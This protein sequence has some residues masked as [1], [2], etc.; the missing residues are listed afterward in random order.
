MDPVSELVVTK[1]LSAQP[2]AV[3]GSIQMNDLVLSLIKDI[4]PLLDI[5]FQSNT[6]LLNHVKALTSMVKKASEQ[7]SCNDLNLASIIEQVC[8]PVLRMFDENKEDRKLMHAV[9]ELL[10]TTFISPQKTVGP[11]NQLMEKLSSELIAIC[12]SSLKSGRSELGCKHSM[13]E[14]KLVKFSESCAIEVLSYILGAQ[15][16]I[17]DT[18]SSHFALLSETE[19]DEAFS[20]L[21]DMVR[22]TNINTTAKIVGSLIM[23]ILSLDPNRTFHKVN[24]LYDLALAFNSEGSNDDSGSNYGKAYLILCALADFILPNHTTTVTS[25]VRKNCKFWACIQTGLISND[26]LTRKRSMYL[27]KRALDVTKHCRKGIETYHEV[28][29]AVFFWSPETEK[30]TDVMWNDLILLLETLDEKQVHVLNPLMPRI[31]NLI[32]ATWSRKEGPSLL[33]TSW[34]WILFTKIQKHDSTYV[35]KWG[36]SVLLELDLKQCPLLE[37]NEVQSIL[38]PLVVMLKEPGLY[39][40]VQDSPVGS[41]PFI[42]DRLVKFLQSCF[43]ALQENRRANF[44]HSLLHIMVSQYWSSPPLLCI[45]QALSSLPAS[46]MWSRKT[47]E[48]LRETMTT[49]LR[50]S[51]PYIRE[52]TICLLVMSV[53]KHSN[54]EDVPPE[55]VA[56]V[57]AVL[58]RDGCFRRG[59]FLYVRCVT[60]L[61]ETCGKKEAS[62]W[63]PKSVA[64]Y[65][66]SSMREILL[67]KAQKDDHKVQKLVRVLLLSVDAGVVNL[68][69]QDEIITM[70]TL[71][72]PVVKTL[73]SVNSRAYMSTSEAQ[74]ALKI[75]TILLTE[76]ESESTDELHFYIHQLV[77]I[78]LPDTVLFVKRT[79]ESTLCNPAQLEHLDVL[80]KSLYWFL[81]GGCRHKQ[82]PEHIIIQDLLQWGMNMM[83]GSVEKERMTCLVHQIVAMETVSILG[84]VLLTCNLSHDEILRQMISLFLETMKNIVKTILERPSDT[85]DSEISTSDRG[86]FISKFLV[87]EIKCVKMSLQFRLGTCGYTYRELLEKCFQAVS[88]LSREFLIPAIQCAHLIIPMVIEE[89]EV[90]VASTL[91]LLWTKTE[92]ETKTAL[93]WEILQEFSNLAFQPALLRCQ[94]KS[95]IME[96]LKKLI[97][98]MFTKGDTKNGI[99][100]PIITNLSR[101]LSTD[102]NI[103]YAVQHLDVLISAC[104][105]GPIYKKNQKIYGDICSYVESLGEE[106]AVN[107]LIDRSCKEDNMVRVHIIN[108]LSHLDPANPDHH[109][110][111]VAFIQALQEKHMEL[112]KIEAKRSFPNSLQHRERYRLMGALLVLEPMLNREEATDTFQTLSTECLGSETQPSVRYLTEWMII[113]L[114]FRFPHLRQ[115]LWKQLSKATEKRPA[116]VCS[117]ISVLAHLGFILPQ[118]Q[119]VAYFAEAIPNFVPWCMAHHFNI[120]IH[121]HAAVN[122]TWRTCK[123]QQF[124]EMLEKYSW[125]EKCVEFSLK[126]SGASKN[127]HKL[128]EDFWFLHKFHPI[129]DYSLETIYHTIPMLSGIIAEEWILPKDFLNKSL[130]W[131][132]EGVLPVHNLRGDLKNCQPGTW[133]I[134]RREGEESEEISEGD[135]QKKVIPWKEMLPSEEMEED[136]GRT[137]HSPGQL[138][139]VTSL[140]DRPP[141]LG[142]LCRTSEIFRVS[143]YVIGNIKYVE[144]KNFQSLC[145][146]AEKWIP[147]KEVPPHKLQTYLTEMQSEGYTLVGV[148]QTANSVSLT[149][150]EFP[151]KTLLLLGNE[152]RG[153]PVDLIQMLDVCVEIPQQGVIRSLNVHVS[154]ALL[155]WEYRRQQ[156]MK[157]VT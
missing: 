135:V 28:R 3:V 80:L 119:Q 35:K 94:M 77:E 48:L 124:V 66:A 130:S 150:Y 116:I 86:S 102:N 100:N 113:K 136:I 111:S 60:W 98:S 2:N 6:T 131:V 10:V 73:Q 126:S 56:S 45:A 101:F 39:M 54:L 147:I 157:T 152:R 144:D 59:T 25:D 128:L 91:S 46:P 107:Q 151:T 14:P 40:R 106:V 139:L 122:K 17:L 84:E 87:A 9:C 68:K 47:L 137:L 7:E 5:S 114:S 96:A 44:F 75:M 134:K 133:R 146:S 37:Q 142:G 27:L 1:V 93:Y 22:D 109:Q 36:M 103:K 58:T 123:E 42:A 153:I 74:Q 83:K 71:L 52:A 85:D 49:L 105:F 97:D 15:S 76:T 140:I 21:M 141:N 69:S 23:K 82:Q 115:G 79:I 20:I 127:T 120:R 125:L 132:G 11:N 70:E 61:R 57:L 51:E 145:V 18:D 50:T 108:L 65:L 129:Q 13:S 156:L 24:Q 149:E 117:L 88:V 34:L 53:L 26:T 16:H 155:I 63:N 62:L 33:H 112:V 92:E 67:L 118:D 78:C 19:L 41:P 64:K 148:E 154:G 31:N 99:V 81:G 29:G 121:A 43:D 95:A 12:K 104:L 89:D 55:D 138:I 30:E 8:F 90:L 38:G 32:K 4:L 143:E 110:F 72:H